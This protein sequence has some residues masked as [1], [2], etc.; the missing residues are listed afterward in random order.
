MSFFHEA[1][2]E[3]LL[4]MNGQ[5]LKILFD[6]DFPNLSGKDGLKH[7]LSQLSKKFFN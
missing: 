1:R 4:P 2:G 7:S 5:R 3:T 6:K